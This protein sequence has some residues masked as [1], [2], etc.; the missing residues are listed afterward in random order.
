MKK[1]IRLAVLIIAAVILILLGTS[2]SGRK[3]QMRVGL[4]IQTTA[5]SEFY[6][7][8]SSSTNPPEYQRYHFYKEN[9][10]WIFYHEKRE[11]NHWPLTE[12]D[13]TA[14]GRI[15]LSTD[16]Q[17]YFF[18]FL[19]DGEVSK[20]K[21]DTSSGGSGPWLYLYWNGD[22]SVYQE[23]SFESY[24]KLKEFEVFCREMTL[25]D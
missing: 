8:Y 6:Y 7:T 20:R 25:K 9:G 22:K 24:G 1:A 10:K 11:G 13:I 4:D 21:E 12:D 15:E 3:R 14:S 23:F 18:G 2:S 19:T 5:I 17:D 16:L